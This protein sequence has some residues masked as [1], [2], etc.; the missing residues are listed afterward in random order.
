MEEKSRSIAL[1]PMVSNRN[2][3]T[4]SADNY[5]NDVSYEDDDDAVTEIRT[6]PSD[7]NIKDLNNSLP[8]IDTLYQ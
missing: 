1:S 5:L 7:F 4:N 8:I 2:S 6:K 3:T